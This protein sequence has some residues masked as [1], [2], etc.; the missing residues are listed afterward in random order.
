MNDLVRQLP[1]VVHGLFMKLVHELVHD[2]KLLLF[3]T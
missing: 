1:F 3:L 2:T